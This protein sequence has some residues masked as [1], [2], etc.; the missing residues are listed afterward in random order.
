MK[1][2][3]EGDSLEV[4]EHVS[5]TEQHGSGVCNVPSNS[6]CKWVACTLKKKKMI[7]EM[8]NCSIRIWAEKPTV[9]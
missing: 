9:H 7:R 5:S 1:K 6:L 8:K 2:H 3:V 4:P